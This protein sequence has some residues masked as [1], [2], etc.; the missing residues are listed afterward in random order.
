MSASFVFA[1][2]FLQIN[3]SVEQLYSSEDTFEGSR[4]FETRGGLAR[5]ETRKFPGAPLTRAG[6]FVL[7][8]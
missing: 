3:I 6:P 2:G 8:A 7:E 5:P 1:Q 4:K